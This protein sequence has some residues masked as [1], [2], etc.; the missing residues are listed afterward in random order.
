MKL[1]ILAEASNVHTRRWAQG[2]A[3]RG[4]GTTVLSA[5]QAPIE[6]V[7]VLPIRVPGF[8]HRYPHRWWTRYA[9]YLRALIR[10][11]GADLVHVHF[12]RDYPFRGLTAPQ[13]HASSWE[14]CDGP[15]L[16]I[17]TWGA[18]IIQDATVPQDTA[19]QRRRKVALLQACDAVT[20][21]TNYLADC[22]ADYGDI[23]REQIT[24]I[25]FGVDLERYAR[26]PDR[27]RPNGPVVGIVKHLQP[28][29]G[30]EYLIRSM[31]AV[32][33][34]FAD[35]RFVIVGEG[36]QEQALKQLAGQLGLEQCIDWRGVIDNVEVPAVLWDMDVFV[37]PSISMSETFG[38][39]AV[40]A[41]AAGV[42][43]VFS[44]LPGVR[45]AVTDGAGGLAVPPGDVSALA[46]AIRHLLADESLRRRLG[47]RGRRAVCDRFTF[48]HNLGQMESVYRK[49]MQRR[50]CAA[51]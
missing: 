20:A 5:R 46:A 3:R 41:Q 36:P 1:V 15:P 28:K 6:G 24:V 30:L 31:P 38:V 8:S 22:T 4:W 42:P 49:A 33:E 16:V 35:A 10:E 29:Y 14:Q 45:E 27:P 26:P 18:D 51:V 11:A 17:S 13:P 40:E 39:V 2:M 32:L 47:E 12:L 23:P 19:A 48:D 50:A 43:V 9:R 7:T 25:P 21:T 34:R 44:D 37:M